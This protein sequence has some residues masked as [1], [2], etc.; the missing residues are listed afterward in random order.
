MLREP[1]RGSFERDWPE[2]MVRVQNSLR[3]RGV[4]E[5]L[6][7]D[8]VQET[9]L[10]LF[11]M[12]SEVDPERSPYGLALRIANN[13]LWDHVRLR[14]NRE[15]LGDVPEHAAP[16]DV[17][18]T[19]LA[20]M[21]LARVQKALPRLSDA[22]RSV[23]LAEIDNAVEAPASSPAAVKMMRMRAR[24]RLTQLLEQVSGF[25]GF[26]GF[27]TRRRAL[28][29]RAFME[30][31][32]MLAEGSAAAAVSGVVATVT[33]VTGATAIALATPQAEPLTEQTYT[34][35][36]P[37]EQAPVITD[38]RLASSDASRS[39]AARTDDGSSEAAARYG[40]EVSP[41]DKVKGKAVVEVR[42]EDSDP[43]IIVPPT[44]GIHR[45]S[46]HRTRVSCTGGRVDRHVIDVETEI[47][48]RP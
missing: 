42:E 46:E 1:A 35:S 30:R 33:V 23:L 12:W 9:G 10:R 24:R 37:R 18:H 43:R 40:I 34:T 44:C 8:I 32:S 7:D 5:W 31:S 17:E 16:N 15:V 21:E 2:L 41:S 6:R 36:A 25:V 47:E 39:A 45:E 13:L 22:H 20:R 19:G 26:L 14:Q 38:A 29:V 11:R 4:P 28:K 27:Q 3:R 48:A